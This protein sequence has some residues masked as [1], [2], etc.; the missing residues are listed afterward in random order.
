MA[1][2]TV[3]SEAQWLAAR[4][5][6]LEKEKAFT[7]AREVLAA[8]RRA[9]PWVEIEKRYAFETKA[10]E[11]SLLELF[12]PNSQLVAYHFMFAPDW[13]AGCHGCSFWADSFNLIGPHLNARD[14]TFLAISRAP[15]A[16]LEAY[17]RRLGWSFDWVSSGASDF[18]RDF[19]V[20]FTDAE[21]EAPKPRYNYG[22]TPANAPE[23][24]GISV[25]IREGARVFHT[26]SSYSRG[27]DMMNAAYQYLDLTPKGRDEDQ[28][29]FSMSWLK[30]RDEYAR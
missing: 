23:M 24:P 13:Q 12:G 29:E 25:F 9:L 1:Q 27:I 20:Y 2:H 4:K 15:L 18:N 19:G 22:S 8:E 30:R 3:V 16:K 6:L 11:Q 28:L 7:H 21:V 5:Q 14:V 17:R 26:Y 10:G